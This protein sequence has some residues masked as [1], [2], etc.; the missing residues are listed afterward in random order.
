VR[1]L[2]GGKKLTREELLSELERAKISTEGQRGYHMLWHLS[3]SGTLCFGPPLKQQQTFVLLD[4]WVKHPLRLQG[5]EALGELARRYFGSHGP[6]TLQDFGTWTKLSAAELK[7]GL[8]VAR[9]ALEELVLGGVTYWMARDAQPAAPAAR[10]ARSVL[11]L[12]GFDEYLLGYRDRSAVLAEEHRQRIAPG[13]NGIFLPTIVVQGQVLG[14]WRRAASSQGVRLQAVPFTTLSA[15]ALKGFELAA[16]EYGRFLGVA[17][18]VGP[19]HQP[20]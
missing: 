20:R 13:A 9:P 7:R 19:K 2:H 1:L 18:S 4:E 17:V 15:A 6:A 11:A 3:Q 12:P 16:S 14:T 10:K 5:D 8:A